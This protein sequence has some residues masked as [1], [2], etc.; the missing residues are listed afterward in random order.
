MDNRISSP[1]FIEMFTFSALISKMCGSVRS[2][3]ITIGSVKVLEMADTP[4]IVRDTENCVSDPSGPPNGRSEMEQMSLADSRE[5]NSLTEM[6]PSKLNG[7]S[8]GDEKASTIV[9][10]VNELVLENDALPDGRP[11]TVVQFLSRK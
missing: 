3:S 9:G 1:E 2:L 11:V 10:S 4:P 7:S 5:A 6:L 8:V